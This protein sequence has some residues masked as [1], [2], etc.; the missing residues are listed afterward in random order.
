MYVLCVGRW[1]RY[2][3]LSLVFRCLGQ[4][5]RVAISRSLKNATSHSFA[6]LTS[7]FHLIHPERFQEAMTT[8][9]VI[10]RTAHHPVHASF[11]GSTS[12]A[13]QNLQGKKIHNL[14]DKYLCLKLLYYMYY[15]I[16][17]ILHVLYYMY[18]IILKSSKSRIQAVI[19]IPRSKR[20]RSC[21]FLPEFKV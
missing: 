20:N 3:Q 1:C 21:I 10:H 9:Q 16:C 8:I 17:I 6:R 12:G 2:R 4:S 11:L 13:R 18:Y 5:R 14:T 19:F 7:S 15:I